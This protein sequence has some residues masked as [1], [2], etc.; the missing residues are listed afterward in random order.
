MNEYT[1][2]IGNTK[3]SYSEETVIAAYFD[4]KDRGIQFVDDK[5]EIVMYVTYENVISIVLLGEYSG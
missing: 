3:S 1:V 4:E 2:Q 5:N